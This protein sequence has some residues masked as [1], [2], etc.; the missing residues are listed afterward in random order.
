MRTV[1]NLLLIATWVSG[2]I[3]AIGGPILIYCKPDY[4]WVS[5]TATFVTFGLFVLFAQIDLRLPRSPWD[6]GK[7]A[8]Q[9]LGAPIFVA[10]KTPEARRLIK[11]TQ[12]QHECARI[13]GES[14]VTARENAPQT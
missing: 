12:L 14:T 9:L 5:I 11:P 6:I 1:R 8:T 10:A 7:R 3:T 13:K 2:S 4:T